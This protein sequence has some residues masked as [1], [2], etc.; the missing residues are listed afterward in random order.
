M[1]AVSIFII[2]I[3][4]GMNTLL[5]ANLLHQK[6]QNMRSILDSMNFAMEDM[7]RN[8]RVG[9]TYD[10]IP[11]NGTIP[12]TTPPYTPIPTSGQ[13]C[14]GIIFKSTA[15]NTLA[16]WVYYIATNPNYP[17]QYSIFKIVDGST[18]VQLTPDEVNIDP[19]S[20]FTVVGAE[21]PSSGN[22]QQPFVTIK[23]VGTIKYQNITTP[24][25]LQTSVSQRT[26]DI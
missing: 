13:N 21:P 19:S 20:S 7:S 12:D 23:L 8:L 25:S 9:Y 18:S 1:I 4:I 15:N 26:I 11:T 24:F 3:M 6:S 2:V 22:Y 5:N 10:C 17:S 14:G 16:T